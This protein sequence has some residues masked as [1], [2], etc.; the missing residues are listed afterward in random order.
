MDLP[1]ESPSL[2]ACLRRIRRWP[3]PP[4]WTSTEWSREVRAQSVA[5]FWQASCE[6]DP[7]RGVPFEAFVRQRVLTA[8]LTRYRQEWTFAIHCRPGEECEPECTARE[9][10]ERKHLVREILTHLSS[11]EIRLITRLYWAGET[12]ITIAAD[13]CL[14][15]QAVSKR[16]MAVLRDLRK[17]LACRTTPA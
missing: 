1:D 15:Q 17:L 10:S 3:V 4:N 9:A 14:T 6:F 8:A 12:E 5:A 11:A 16:K 7:G 2:H 13:V